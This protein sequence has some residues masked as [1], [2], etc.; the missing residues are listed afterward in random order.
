MVISAIPHITIDGPTA[1]GKGTVA[2]MVAAAL[3]WHYLDS[4]AIYRA[5]ALFAMDED[6]PL[7]DEDRV[8]QLGGALPL[9]FDANGRIFLRH[10]DVTDAIRAE[11]IGNAASQIASAPKVRKAL[12]ERQRDF[13]QA[14]GLVT[15]GRDMG[16]VVFPNAPLKIFLTA[17]AQAR[18]ER[19]YKQLIEKG[20]SVIMVDL[21]RDLEARD[22]RDA[23]RATAPLAF[24]ENAVLLDTSAMDAS[25]AADFVLARWREV[26]DQ[27]RSVTA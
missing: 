6:V 22:L 26:L 5:T 27:A 20:N 17:S 15:D 1:S 25:A 2:Q 11:A 7:H 24:A 4:G 14:P 19:R 10:D 8:A 23:S 3:G 16:T 21:V 13:L 9:R 18:A 12:L